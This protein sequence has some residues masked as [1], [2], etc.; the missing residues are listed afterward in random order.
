MSD[1]SIWYEECDNGWLKLIPSVVKC[2]YE[3]DKFSPIVTC[4]HLPEQ[5]LD[6]FHVFPKCTIECTQEDFAYQRYFGDNKSIISYSGTN[7]T[8]QDPTM[9][10]FLIYRI[11]FYAKFKS[12]ID[13]ITRQWNT[14]CGRAFS[15]PVTLSTGETYNCN[16]DSLG[17]QN[18]DSVEREVRRYVR[19]Y[20]YKVWAYLEGDTHDAHRVTNINHITKQAGGNNYD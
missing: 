13:Y 18:H 1:R 2:E 12:D 20:L 17:C 5:D 9:P 3:Q 11:N 15:L 19:S 16:V 6:N 14:F 8:V 4:I 10:Y 7:A